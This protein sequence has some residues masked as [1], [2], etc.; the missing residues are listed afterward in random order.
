[1]KI[2]SH[3]YRW[4]SA[5]GS[6][7]PVAKNRELAPPVNCFVAWNVTESCHTRGRSG[8]AGVMSV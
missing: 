3:P 4:A 2:Y 6:G 1:M 8:G 7:W 5:V